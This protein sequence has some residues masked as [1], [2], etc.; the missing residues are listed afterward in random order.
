MWCKRQGQIIL[1]KKRLYLMDG[2]CSSLDFFK[3]KFQEMVV[4]HNRKLRRNP[5][6]LF[7]S[8]RINKKG[9]SLV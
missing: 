5:M 8:M 9:T 3:A 7:S 6:D 2:L 4:V 1:K